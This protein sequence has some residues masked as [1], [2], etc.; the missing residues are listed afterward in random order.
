M[1]GV[2]Q[3]RMPGDRRYRQREKS[4]AEGIVLSAQ[5]LVRLRELASV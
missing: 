4:L 1:H 5:D 3:Q 2:G